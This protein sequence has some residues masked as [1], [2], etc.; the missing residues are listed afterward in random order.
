MT[1]QAQQAAF[2][3]PLEDTAAAAPPP[4]SRGPI[5][6]GEED[7]VPLETYEAEPGDCTGPGEPG[8]DDVGA[9][10]V[11]GTDGGGGMLPDAEVDQ[12]IQSAA[13]L[14]ASEAAQRFLDRR[15]QL[16]R[17]H[18][19]LARTD[20]SNPPYV[21]ALSLHERAQAVLEGLS[22]RGPHSRETLALARTRLATLG[23][24]ATALDDRLVADL[25]TA[26]S[27]EAA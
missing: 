21:L 5:A 6:H 22:Q 15:L 20:L 19:P 24:L 25:R 8:P 18:G 26:K 14:Y 4:V 7:F 27:E 13:G 11:R 12:L 1:A 9:G 16:Q 2:A 10:A 17:E 23:A 3:L